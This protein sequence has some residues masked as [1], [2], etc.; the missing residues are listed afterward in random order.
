MTGSYATPDLRRFITPSWSMKLR[1][2]TWH[3]LKYQRGG[4]RKRRERER[5]LCR[6]HTAI[7]PD[8]TGGKFCKPRENSWSVTEYPTNERLEPASGAELLATQSQDLLHKVLTSSFRI[9]KA[10]PRLRILH[11][12]LP[13]IPRHFVAFSV[14]G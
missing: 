4:V 9:Q 3:L 8:W 5:W 1:L 11:Q 2:S 10:P 14:A 13:S 7:K 6:L 12:P